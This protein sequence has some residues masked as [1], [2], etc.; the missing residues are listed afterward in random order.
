MLPQHQSEDFVL[1]T[2]V[3]HCERDFVNAAGREFYMLIDWEGKSLQESG[4]LDGKNIVCIDPQQVCWSRLMSPMLLLKF[5]GSNF[6]RATIVSMVKATASTI[7]VL[8]SL[9]FMVLVISIIQKI[10]MSY[11]S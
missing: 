5:V 3:Q 6:S 10:A 7:S 1:A 9:I 11:R 2:C 4:S 8:C